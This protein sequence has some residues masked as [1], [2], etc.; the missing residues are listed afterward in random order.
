MLKTAFLPLC[1]LNLVLFFPGIL[2]AAS[3]SGRV[4]DAGSS[5]ALPGAVVSIEGTDFGAL[6]TTDGYYLIADIPPGAYKVDFSAMGSEML[7]RDI[8]VI[9][10]TAI[11]LDVR[12]P[13]SPIQLKEVKV[14]AQRAEFKQE[15]RVSTLTLKNMVMDHAPRLLSN[16][17]LRAIQILPGVNT[18]S[19]FSAASFIRGGNA[20]QNQTLI[21]GVSLYNPTHLA[22][23]FSVVDQDAVKSAD[24]LTGGFPANYGGRLSSVLDIVTRDGNA[25]RFTG[26]VAASFLS[27]SAML[28]GPLPKGSFFIRGQRTYFDQVLKLVNFNFPYY[29]YDLQGKAT[30]HPTQKTTLWGSGFLSNDLY[31]MGSGGMGVNLGWGNRF[32]TVN[33]QQDWSPN[34]LGKTSLYG[35]GYNLDM[36]LAQGRFQM[37]DSI[38]EYGLNSSLTWL[39]PREQ[40]LEAGIQASLPTFRFYSTGLGPDTINLNGPLTTVAAYVQAKLKP[41][42]DLLIQPGL[43]L[44]YYRAHGQFS[45]QHFTPSPR[46]SAKYFLNDITA[47]KG[48]WGRYYQ[49]FSALQPEISPIPVLFFW[50]PVFGSYAPQQA[51]HYVLG[52]ERWLDENTNL[53]VEGFHKHYGRIYEMGNTLNPDSIM[54]GLLKPGTGYSTGADLL[55]RRDWGRLTGMLS[56]SLCFARVKFDSLEYPPSYDRRHIVNLTLSYTLPRGW[57]LSA[58]WNYGSGLPYTATVGYLRD[59]NYD[60]D[61]GGAGYSWVDIGSGK[62]LARYPAYHRLDLGAEKVYRIGKTNLNVQFN[63]FNAYYRKNVLLYYWDYSKTPPQRLAQSQLP[64]IP[65]LGVK[66]SF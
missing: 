27:A 1:A 51:D 52:V 26:N 58:H 39:L 35:S 2:D 12:L 7:T 5:E 46:L 49:F 19:D 53:T 65:S 24:L 21:D 31:S 37:D 22:G 63:L 45:G 47:I 34:L 33:W 8:V 28:E 17:L 23:L 10:D 3:V 16:D 25:N 43:R 41:I 60:Y 59:W 40:E 32:A 4:R 61:D 50:V 48:A 29:F 54:S 38:N 62:N 30:I 13:Q 64:I 36:N 44:D 9:G 55:L 14:T 15:T 42:P 56:Y 57:S 66:W 20:D 18:T 11:R 6:T